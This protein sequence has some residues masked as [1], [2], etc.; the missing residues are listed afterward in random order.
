MN[1]WGS[2]VRRDSFEKKWE[3]KGACLY[4]E[5]LS[6]GN[7]RGVLDEWMSGWDSM[8]GDLSLSLGFGFYVLCFIFVF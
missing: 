1:E 8:V 3:R 2:R 7:R 5:W 4:G 6:D